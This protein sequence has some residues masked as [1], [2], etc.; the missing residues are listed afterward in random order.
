MDVTIVADLDTAAGA[1]A[2]LLCDAI[3][4]RP[5]AVLGLPAGQTPLPLYAEL[6]RRCAVG[7]VDFSQVTT[8]NLDE[9]EGVSSGSP[10]SF[11]RFMHEHLFAGVNMEPSRINCLDGLA[12]DVIAECHRYETAIA[13]RGGIDLQVLGIGANGHIGFNEPAVVLSVSTHRAELSVGTRQANASLFDG[14]VNRVPHR[15]LTMGIGTILGAREV[16]LMAAGPGKAD[17]IARMIEG[18][19]TTHLPASLLQ[20][21]RRVRVFVDRSAAS[22]LT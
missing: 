12:T 15:A 6:R 17:S 3:A 1:V 19:L 21:H 10:G 22:R 8:F 20:L 14:D 16:I 11:R 18:G 13:A 4:A 5:S 9:F 7:Q 2:D